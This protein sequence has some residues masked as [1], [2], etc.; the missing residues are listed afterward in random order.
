MNMIVRRDPWNLLDQWHKELD[1]MFDRRSDDTSR[2][3]GSDWTP[4]VDIKEEADRYLL[5]A[6]IPG[7]K[8]DDIE[9]SMDKGVLTIKGE[10]KHEST[11]SKEGYK[12]VERSH[13]IFM[14]RFSLPDGVDG[15][16]I[17]ASSKD[18]VLEVVIPKSEPEKPRRIEVK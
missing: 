1:N 15:E 9:V 10:R 5:H 14:R 13:G 7:V 4:A 6:D 18:G 3:E 8:A 16:N 2:I 12:R 11:E 17:S